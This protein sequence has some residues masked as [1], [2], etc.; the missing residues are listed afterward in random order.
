MQVSVSG[1]QDSGNQILGCVINFV[2]VISINSSS[3]VLAFITIDMT[4]AVKETLG[5]F[6]H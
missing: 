4:T 3:I 6:I 1:M 2:F 5:A